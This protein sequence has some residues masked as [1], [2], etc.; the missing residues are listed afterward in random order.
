[1]I[2]DNSNHLD[3]MRK[4][5]LEMQNKLADIL[6]T[7]KAGIGDYLVEVELNGKHEATKVTINPVLTKE[8]PEAI[9]DLVAAA[10]TD[11][12]HHLEEKI[13]LELVKLFQ[14]NSQTS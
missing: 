9:G 12:T 11:A 14:N 10:I 2:L 6:A 4:K 13:K 8:N 3:A 7:G 1:M 5:S